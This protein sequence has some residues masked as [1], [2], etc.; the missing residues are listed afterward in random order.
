MRPPERD[1]TGQAE[2]GRAAPRVVPDAA[3]PGADRLAAPVARA[4]AVD[5]R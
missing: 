1:S 4:A 3:R 2:L 5:H